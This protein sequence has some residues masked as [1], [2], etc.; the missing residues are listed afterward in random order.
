MSYRNLILVGA[1]SIFSILMGVWLIKSSFMPIGA[2][3]RSQGG[4]FH[5]DTFVPGISFLGLG[6]LLAT[7]M[8]QELKQKRKFEQKE[9][10]RRK[11][12]HT[13]ELCESC[14]ERASNP[15]NPAGFCDI[16]HQELLEM[17]EEIEREKKR[18]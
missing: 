17:A 3:W 6:A 11:T 7:L 1:S 18:K 5:A 4:R 10:E 8:F 14:G 9:R 15:A 13:E 16:C 12:G 2:Q